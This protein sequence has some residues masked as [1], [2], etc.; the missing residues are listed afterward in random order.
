MCLRTRY[1][2]FVIA[3]STRRLS[4]QAGVVALARRLG[5]LTSF[6]AANGQRVH[7]STETLIRVMASLG[8]SI[9]T[10]NDARERL[11]E[12]HAHRLVIEPVIAL[13]AGMRSACHVLLPQ[14][15]DPSSVEVHVTTEAGDTKTVALSSL[16]GA[17]RA[18]RARTGTDQRYEVVLSKAIALPV[19]YHHV[20]ITGSGLNA[21]ALVVVAPAHCPLPARSWGVFAPLHAAR[22]EHDWGVGSFSTLAEIGSWTNELGGDFVSTLPLN[23]TF[24]SGPMSDISPY[25]PVSR[26]AWNELFIDVERVPEYSL[27]PTARSLVTS[28]PFQTQLTTLRE[29]RYA[30]LQRVLA[31]KREVLELCAEALYAGSARRD[32]LERFLSDRPEIGA[33]ARFRALTE[34][35]GEGWR[36]WHDH[37]SAVLD[38]IGPDNPRFRYHCYVQW[39]AEAQLDVARTGAG[40][41]L[42]LPVGVHPDGFDPF[43]F[44]PVFADHVAVGASPDIFQP[45][46]QN[47]SVSPLHPEGLRANGYAYLIAYLRHAMRHASVIRIDHVMGLH[48]LWWIPEGMEPAEGAY[49][50]YRAAELRAIL[51]LEAQRLGVGIVGEDLGTVAPSVRS[52]MRRDHMLGCH[53]HEF[54]ATSTDPLPNPP[55]NSVASIGTHD[56]PTFEAWWDGLDIN[57]RALHHE[58]NA[59][60]AENA[61]EFR[62]QIRLATTAHSSGDGRSASMLAVLLEHLARGPA[63]MLLVD[64]EDLWLEKEPQN[65]PGTGQEALNFRRRWAHSLM[66]SASPTM[67][68][69]AALLAKIDAARRS[70]IESE[71]PNTAAMRH[72]VST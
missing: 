68:S 16:L 41:Y 29:L 64:I 63:R 32:E 38:A 72:S 23:A 35:R 65:R 67:T 39:I 6:L 18:L 17:M 27:A 15:V 45:R 30:D 11:A 10:P 13:R 61:L 47:W 60:D 14:G 33:Y 5:I 54:A 70:S 69:I 9:E 52:G 8:T 12:L 36:S 58:M 26:L 40:L 66:S 59:D 55:E 1:S 43:W 4:G 7:A 25:R 62:R 57:E 44:G 2:A 53:V 42:D 31:V 37:K 71:S 50:R 56:L 3:S 49:V 48:R 34:E 24:L 51:V 46:G 21:S 22:E 20:D 19:G 28:T